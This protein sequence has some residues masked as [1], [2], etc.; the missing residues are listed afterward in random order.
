MKLEDMLSAPAA[1]DYN[2]VVFAEKGGEGDLSEYIFTRSVAENLS[3]ILNRIIS[4]IASETE[5]TGIWI[6]GDFGSGKSHFL[7][8]LSLMLDGRGLSER[9]FTETGAG[10]EIL[11]AAKRIEDL[12]IEPILFNIDM[13]AVKGGENRSL[14]AAFL[15]VFNKNCGY[16]ENNP[17]VAEFERYLAGI[18]KYE[19]F[20]REFKSVSGS[21]WSSRRGEPGFAADYIIKATAALG[22]MSSGAIESVCANMNSDYRTSIDEFAGV[23][24]EHTDKTGAA[25]VFL[26]DEIGQFIGGDTALMLELQTIVEALSSSCR[27][28]AWIVVTSQHEMNIKDQNA[29]DFSKIRGRFALKV[30]LK[31]LETEEIV[32]KRF[33][34][35][36]RSG[37]VALGRTYSR[38]RLKF[39]DTIYSDSEEVFE[40]KAQF[41]SLYPFAPYQFKLLPEVL[42]NIRKRGGAGADISTAE[43]SI[44]SVFHSALTYMKAIEKNGRAIAPLYAFYGGLREFFSPDETEVVEDADKYLKNERIGGAQ[45]RLAAN[46]LKTLLILKYSNSIRAT[47]GNLLKLLISDLKQDTDKATTELRTALAT[48]LKTNIIKKRGDVFAFLSASEIAIENK[49][50]EIDV[51]NHEIVRCIADILFGKIF[52]LKKI[53]LPNGA[54]V[55]L[56][57]FIDG[58]PYKQIRGG[59]DVGVNFITGL[60]EE[61]YNDGDLK[62]LS[63]ECRRTIVLLDGSADSDRPNVMESFDEIKRAIRIEKYIESVGARNL[64][65]G[66]IKIKNEEKI[67]LMSRAE[68]Y[69][70]NAA[71]NALVYSLGEKV[72]GVTIKRAAERLAAEVYHKNALINEHIGYDDIMKELTYGA[73]PNS[74]KY[75]QNAA[76]LD[77]MEEYIGLSGKISVDEVKRRFLKPPYGYP[78]SDTVWLILTLLRDK[79]I[80]LILNGVHTDIFKISEPEEIFGIIADNKRK[81]KPELFGFNDTNIDK[82]NVLTKLRGLYLELSDADS[83]PDDSFIASSLFTELD[84][85][86]TELDKYSVYYIAEDNLKAD[87][88]FKYP[89]REIIASGK[90]LIGEVCPASDRRELETEINAVAAK[91]D[92]IT[93]FYSKFE[94]VREFFK[95]DQ[96]KIYSMAAALCGRIRNIIQFMP[97]EKA[98]KLYTRITE[99]LCDGEPYKRIPELRERYL[100]LND[101][102]YNILNA[103]KADAR[104]KLAELAS[105]AL[106]TG[107][108]LK[109]LA[110]IISDSDNAD[111]ILGVMYMID[112]A[113]TEGGSKSKIKEH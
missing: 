96:Y 76:A 75:K 30:S 14:T 99:I 66:F 105:G 71:D 104:N 77:D 21:D 111:E 87:N 102:Y 19:D 95:S 78:Q 7:K 63:G 56:G 53:A 106:Y 27:G 35:K 108:T 83:A 91:A 58:A 42:D 86:R 57:R 39:S 54:E 80:G 48:L 93:G 79:R 92:E 10:S 69:L 101:I 85:L 46:I 26:A 74:V 64:D 12:N 45:K 36:N 84:K 8:T 29:L 97:D 33:L 67:E 2:G 22:V 72:F 23:V 4:G 40:D 37:A 32:V 103:L 9:N 38:Y 47:E 5:N 65:D 68:I 3:L 60:G 1:D 100:E 70:K 34:E 88:M 89:G 59:C 112:A 43:R 82:E 113:D 18:G 110:K 51:E 52:T 28:R 109:E 107:D 17:A 50:S 61:S 20:K 11:E 44:L 49:I 15:N 13:Q 81:D 98:K 41:I 55:G 90:E 25:V 31:S 73:K 24:R 6:S 62:L 94:R 16:C